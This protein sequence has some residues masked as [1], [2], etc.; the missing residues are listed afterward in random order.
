[1]GQSPPA[2]YARIPRLALDILEKVCGIP[3]SVAGLLV[4]QF[5]FTVVWRQQLGNLDR[6]Y[7]AV[8]LRGTHEKAAIA[9][10]ILD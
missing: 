10:A 1:M 9:F 6:V 5:L 7:S 3:K 2:L 4:A 8:P